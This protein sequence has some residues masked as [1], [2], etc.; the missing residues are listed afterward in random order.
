MADDN[1][2]N[3]LVIRTLLEQFGIETITVDSGTAAIE[4]WE[5]GTWSAILM[6]IHMPGMDGL[7]ATRKSAPANRPAAGPTSRSSLSP[8]AS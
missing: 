4:A 8:P 6:D 1:P 7:D 2:T 3:R 5:G